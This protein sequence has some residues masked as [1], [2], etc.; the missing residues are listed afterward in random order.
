VLANGTADSVSVTQ[1]SGYA[2]LDQA[3]AKAVWKWRFQPSSLG[4]RSV[5][6]VIPYRI[7]FNLQDAH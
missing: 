4:G 6:S 5:P 2:I 7:H 1:S 3:A